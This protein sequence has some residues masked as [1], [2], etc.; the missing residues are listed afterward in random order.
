MKFNPVKFGKLMCAARRIDGLGLKRVA[1]IIDLDYSYL[2]LLEN[3]KRTPSMAVF[4]KLCGFYRM[5][6]GGTLSQCL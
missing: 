3:G 4:V 1:P 6:P 5:D 2:S